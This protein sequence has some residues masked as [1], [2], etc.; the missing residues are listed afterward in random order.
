MPTPSLGAGDVIAG[1]FRLTAEIGEGGMGRVYEAVDLLH[2][3]QAAVKV[4][5]RRLARDLEFRA[6]FQREAQAAERANHP[7]VLPIWDYGSEGENL[8]M[9]TPLCDADLAALLHERGPLE[10]TEALRIVEQIAWA[11][12]WAH[13]RGVVHRDVKPENILIV[14]GPREAH[15]YLADFGMARVASSATLTQAGAPVGLSPAY[16]APEQWRGNTVGPATDQYALA[17]TLY[18][19]V[20]GTPPFGVR[21]VTELREAHL[22]QDPRPPKGLQASDPMSRALLVALSKEPGDRYDSC[23]ELV[24]AVQ[25]AATPTLP[26]ESASDDGGARAATV[27]EHPSSPGRAQPDPTVSVAAAPAHEPTVAQD[28]TVPHEPT[29]VAQDAT[30]PH[31]P[32]FVAQDATAPHEPAAPPPP[33]EPTQPA[34]PES[35]PARTPPAPPAS[36]PAAAPARRRRRAP[37]V[38][39]GVAALAAAAAAAVLA[40]GG[41]GDGGGGSAAADRETT[42]QQPV[43]ANG[44]ARVAVGRGPVDIA[45]GAGAV[46]VADSGASTLTRISAGGDG[47]PQTD[48]VPAMDSP[49]GVAVGGDFVWAAGA[50]GEILALNGKSG[51][52]IGTIDT[53]NQTDGLTLTRDALWVFNGTAGTVTRLGVNRG[54][55]AAGETTTQ[56]GPGLTDIASGEGSVWVTNSSAGT[57]V[58]LD[59]DSGEVVRTIPMRGAVDSVAVADGAVWVANSERGR[60]VRVDPNDATTVFAQVGKGTQEADVAAGDGAVFY[61]DHDTGTAT[62]VDPDSG[63]PVGRPTVVAK[64]PTSAVVADEALWVTD[65]ADNTVTRLPF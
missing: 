49:F 34:E 62:R 54:R 25:L 61:V 42:A 2:E 23:G 39:L 3:R 65:G 12:D 32:T 13:G 14:R 50:G 56:V 1:R 8:Y 59:E 38:V 51:E 26:A 55:K 6:R 43:E 63:Q 30:A 40:T 7:H 9:A 52:G 18:A 48:T 64:S 27:P 58:Q 24:A 31:Q 44:L 41:G 46:W 10:P 28:A 16:A 20:A 57:L 60:L 37:L 19:C 53:A 29:F 36:A 35:E 45:A 33:R 15:A 11:L 4:I 47:K 17:A 22:Y 5:S 21:S